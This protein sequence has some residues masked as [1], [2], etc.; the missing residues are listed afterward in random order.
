V[1][2]AELR[3]VLVAELIAAGRDPRAELACLVM[4]LQGSVVEASRALVASRL[5]AAPATRRSIEKATAKAIELRP[6]LCARS[7]HE[8]TVRDAL[9]LVA[10]L[11]QSGLS[12]GTIALY[13]SKLRLVFD[14]AGAEPNPLR[15]A[16]VRLPS[17]LRPET[18]PPARDELKAIVAALPTRLRLAVCVLEQ[19]AMRVGELCTLTWADVDVL[20]GRFRL[21][22]ERVKT[23]HPRWVQLEP[24]LADLIAASCPF[25]DRSPGR[26]VFFA[27]E[28]ALRSALARACRLAG[29]VLYSPHDLRH[30]RASL[31]HDQGLSTRELMAR[32]GWS[33]SEI[34]IDTYSHVLL[35][36]GELTQAEWCA[37]L[38]PNAEQRQPLGVAV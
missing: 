30:R 17:Q 35:D 6:A 36:S 2:E 19:T 22:R 7:C 21:S 26:S 5:D 27:G 14:F 24:W 12:A 28:D 25:D 4:R 18:S 1:R 8:W 38:Q 34:A 10:A 31:W 3:R 16:R 32:G 20:N 33:R 23:R 9:E 37:L 13:V 11:A 29:T 15:D